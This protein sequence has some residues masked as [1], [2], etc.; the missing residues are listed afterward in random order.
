MFGYLLLNQASTAEQISMKFGTYYSLE[1]TDGRV[2]GEAHRL[3]FI[4]ASFVSLIQS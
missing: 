2:S 1:Y 3:L 4:P